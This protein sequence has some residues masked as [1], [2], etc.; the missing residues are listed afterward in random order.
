MRALLAI[1]L[2]L[3]ALWSGYWWYGASTIETAVRDWFAAQPPAIAQTSGVE[4]Q[5]IPNRF[6]LTVNGLKL[7]DP[8]SGI[9]WE[10]PF[11]QVYAM[12]WKPWHIIAALPTGQ[13]IMLPD[14]TIGL[15]S[16]RMIG[17]VIVH[18]S[19][20]LALQE[21]VTDLTAV[22]LRSDAGWTVGFGRGLASLREDS[23]RKNGYRIGLKV[24][25]IAPDPSVLAA[26][27]ST[28]LPPTIA[29][30]YLDAD[31]TLSAPLD[32]FAQTSQPKLMGLKLTEGRVKWGDLQFHVAGDL[33]PDAQGFASG[34]LD[35]RLNG[36][37]DLPPVLAALGLIK[38]EIMPTVTNMLGAMAQQSGNPEVVELKLKCADGRMNLGPFPLG[39][40]PRFN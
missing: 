39:P 31:A 1:M 30:V 6:D 7:H 37:K 9:G 14:Q 21:V 22:T 24:T 40:A 5:G 34:T 17:D 18:P 35:L 27:T 3:T 20:D 38:P 32:R 33:T 13:E 10:T 16:D 19:T 12:T 2:T 4:V 25:E 8:A 26:L 23:S 36:W 11:A 15:Q 29:E 28:T